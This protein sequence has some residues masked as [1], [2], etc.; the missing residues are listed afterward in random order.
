[1]FAFVLFAATTWIVATAP[2][3]PKRLWVL[4]ILAI[5]WANLHGSFFLIPLLLGLTWLENVRRRPALARTA[6]AAALASLVTVA[7]NPYGF[8]V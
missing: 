3:N 5:A 2:R 6:L 7:V 8:R 1:M 4:P